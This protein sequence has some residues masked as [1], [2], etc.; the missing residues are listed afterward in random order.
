MGDGFSNIPVQEFQ[1]AD[2]GNDQ[3]R[4]NRAV[5]HLLTDNLKDGWRDYAARTSL[6][7]KVPLIDKASSEHRLAAWM[8]G[9]L[10]KTR[11]LVRAAQ[12]AARLLYAGAQRPGAHVT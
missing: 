12:A 1:C 7:G 9:S 8:G 3:A 2:P 6:P 5:L 4:L 11:L 10:K